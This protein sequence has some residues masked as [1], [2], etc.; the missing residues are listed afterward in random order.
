VTPF[1]LTYLLRTRLPAEAPKRPAYT[2]ADS[3]FLEQ[4]TISD[5]PVLNLPQFEGV[6]P[7]NNLNRLQAQFVFS[8]ALYRSD[9]FDQLKTKTLRSL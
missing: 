8:E 1:V 7:I 9:V 5:M 2:L 3:P 6:E 4:I